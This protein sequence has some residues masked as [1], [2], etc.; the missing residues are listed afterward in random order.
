MV[1][2]GFA[3]WVLNQGNSHLASCSSVQQ[4]HSPHGLLGKGLLEI[5]SW[6]KGKIS[7]RLESKSHV[8]LFLLPRTAELPTS[9]PPRGN[10]NP[11]QGWGT[12]ALLSGSQVSCRT[13]TRPPFEAL[14]S[15]PAGPCRLRQAQKASGDARLGPIPSADFSL[16]Q[17]SISGAPPLAL[18]QKE[19]APSP[20][21][22]FLPDGGRGRGSHGSESYHREPRR[23][24][25]RVSHPP[26]LG[27]TL[28]VSQP[29]HPCA[30]D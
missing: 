6:R 8:A 22:C 27:G 2:K 10:N 24:P 9:H 1:S 15:Q 23:A 17:A 28:R 7:W 20:A 21:P 11:Q 5:P 30:L 14:G 26:H 29:A 12:N 19:G 3:G 18:S 16:L 13:M 25:P 4:G